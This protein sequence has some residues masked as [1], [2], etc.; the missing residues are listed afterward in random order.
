MITNVR[1]IGISIPTPGPKSGTRR[2]AGVRN[3][4]SSDPRTCSCRSDVPTPQR[5]D[6]SHIYMAY[7]TNT[8]PAT[9]V[10]PARSANAASACG[11][12]PE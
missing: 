11:S 5:R 10:L 3:T 9:F 8:K 1:L 12:L 2:D 7:P 6:D 4:A